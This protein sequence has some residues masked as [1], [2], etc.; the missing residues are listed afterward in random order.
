MALCFVTFELWTIKKLNKYP[1]QINN[2]Q[3][4]IGQEESKASKKYQEVK[5]NVVVS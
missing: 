2:N 5:H 4:G 1:K 3:C